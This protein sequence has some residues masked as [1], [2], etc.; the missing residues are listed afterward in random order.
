MKEG[1]ERLYCKNC[2]KKKKRK[3][4]L[5]TTQLLVKRQ[6]DELSNK[7]EKYKGL[8]LPRDHYYNHHQRLEWKNGNTGS[9]SSAGGSLIHFPALISLFPTLLTPLVTY[10]EHNVYNV[11]CAVK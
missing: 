3:K 11:Q 10:T 2:K 8:L 1:G 5:S 4:R 6:P 7:Y 9:F